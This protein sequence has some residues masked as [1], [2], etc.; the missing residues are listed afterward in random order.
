MGANSTVEKPA[1]DKEI[2]RTSV[3]LPKEHYNILASVAEQNR[4]SVAWVVRDAVARYVEDRWPLLR[5]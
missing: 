4:V 1:P 3:S 2:V 5:G